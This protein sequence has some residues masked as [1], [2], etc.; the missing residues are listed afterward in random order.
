MEQQ[1]RIVEVE[2]KNGE[3][4]KAIA[5]GNNAAW[6]CQCK[7]EVPLIGTTGLVDHL[8]D[9]LRVDCPDCG[10][11]YHVIPDGKDMGPVLKVIEV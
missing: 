7:R 6:I 9:G 10:C 3:K 11:R 5:T 2:L 4:S 1:Q 8:T